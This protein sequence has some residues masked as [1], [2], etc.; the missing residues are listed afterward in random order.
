MFHPIH[1]EPSALF[2]FCREAKYST[3]RA[4]LHTFGIQRGQAPPDPLMGSETERDSFSVAIDGLSYKGKGSEA[5]M[6]G[7]IS[8]NS[9]VLRR[10]VSDRGVSFGVT[11]IAGYASRA[12]FSICLPSSVAQICKECFNGGLNLCFVSLEF[13]SRLCRFEKGTFG[14]C[15]SLTS[16]C[17]PSTVEKV[18]TA[19]FADPLSFCAWI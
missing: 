6:S 15:G 2:S 11:S 4:L 10:V 1:K 18:C 13:E 14:F 19:N 5:S 7:E 3:P 16:I 8:G 12:L 9:G 17:I